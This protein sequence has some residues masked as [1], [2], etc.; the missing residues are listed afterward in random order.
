MRD[1]KMK[2]YKVLVKVKLKGHS[3]G[4][5]LGSL[6]VK[7]NNKKEATDKGAKAYNDYIN[8]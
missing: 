3:G 8:G 2:N 5:V 4:F 6:I 7:A 1:D